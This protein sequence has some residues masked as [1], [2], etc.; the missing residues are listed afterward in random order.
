MTRINRMVMKGFKSFG[1]RVELEFG[2][3]FNCVLGPN[4]AGKSNVLDALCFVLGKG[5]AK[6]LRA[7]KAANLIYNGGKKKEPAKQGEVSIYFDNSKKTFPT[8]D[9]FVKITRIIR[10]SGQ[11]IYRINDQKRTRQEILDLLAIANIDPDSYNIVLQGDIVRL[12]EMGPVE[13]RLII[14]DIAGISQYEEK[15]NKAL[16]ELK[17]VEEKLGEAHIILSERKTYLKELKKDRDQAMQ[18]KEVADSLKRAKATYNHLRRKEREERL[19]KLAKQIE[20]HHAQIKAGEEE[21]AGLKKEV[22]EK[23]N[24]IS[25][26]TR[27]IEEKGEKEQVR[28]MKDIE[29]LRIDIATNRTRISSDEN[30]IMRIQ[31]RKKQL[32]ASIFELDERTEEQAEKKNALEKQ[33]AEWQKQLGYIEGRIAQFRKKH[34]IEDSNQM[35]LDMDRLDE[36]AEALQKELESLREE[37]QNLLREKDRTEMYLRGIDERIAKV[38]EI[39]KEHRSDVLKLKQK[40][41]DFKST[42]LELNS[43]LNEDS[44]LAAQLGN[45]RAKL[46]SAQDELSKLRARSGSIQQKLADSIAVKSIMDRKGSLGNVYGSISDLGKVPSKYSLAL[47]VAAGPRIKSLVVDTDKTAAACIKYLKKN[48]LG[49]AAFLPLNKIKGTEKEPDAA[50]LRTQ[51]VQGKAIDL[52][53]FDSKFKNAFRYVFGST[54]VVENIDVARRVGVGTVR[55]VT[56]DGDIVELSGAMHGGYRQKAAGLAFQ[57][58]EVLAGIREKEKAAADLELLVLGIDKKRAD[59]QARIQRLREHKAALEGEIIKGEKSLHLESGDLD[60]SRKEK[61]E[62]AAAQKETEKKLAAVSQKVTSALKELT[63]IKVRKQELRNKISEMRSP[64]VLAELN[65]FEQKKAELKEQLIRS[66]SEIKSASM[67]TANILLPEKEKIAKILGQLDKEEK[68]FTAEIAGL[69]A[70]IRLQE[71]ELAQKEKLQKQF[72]GKYKG[73]FQEKDRANEALQRLENRIIKTEE[74][75]RGSEQ[76]SNVLSVDAAAIKAELAGLREEAAKYAGVQLYRGKGEEELRKEIWQMER[77]MEQAGNINMRALEVYDEIEKE[78]NSLI[79]KQDKLTQEK[80]E[81]LVM[82]NEIETKKKDQ[83]METFGLVDKNFQMM[84]GNLTTKGE[85]FLELENPKD[86]L[87]EGLRIKVRIS[88]KKF[89]DIR[90]LSGGEKTLTALAFIFAIQEFE[91]ASFYV[92]DEVDAALDKRNSEKLAGLIESYSKKAQYILISHNDTIISKADTLYGIS[93]D[94]NSMSKVV[95]LKL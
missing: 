95:T 54:I 40:R 61:K 64:T 28:I 51:G 73:L 47:Q 71:K 38:L 75:I 92:L 52:I 8:E 94:E 30:E 18:Y 69:G 77:T 63:S 93:M 36:K 66:D 67:Q 6:G 74:A 16:N 78:Y 79:E 41:A 68:S 57:E 27:E 50:V 22:A 45:A 48:R 39:E 85:A 76:K 46:A 70:K 31:E 81:V 58:K 82:I 80:E 4:G 24:R 5:S 60:A 2:P 91:P 65:T 11:S 43:L 33:K 59:A 87:A 19:G 29:K 56:L 7:D 12:V 72:Y 26:L 88:G 14:E 3:H 53:D 83:F 37:Q 32:Q 89:L 9:D 62:Y 49:T 44:A 34:K 10:G 23:K 1:K 20:K 15:K 55:M 86:P 17:K 25:Q 13:R 90:S 35:E 84:F 21:I 42:T